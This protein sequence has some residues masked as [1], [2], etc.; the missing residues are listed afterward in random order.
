MD[1][2]PPGPAQEIDRQ[3]N[4]LS[5]ALAV[6]HD[7]DRYRNNSLFRSGTEPHQASSPGHAN[8]ARD[9]ATIT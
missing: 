3:K 7:P 2:D 4:E 1:E 8:G 6:C 5:L 9:Q